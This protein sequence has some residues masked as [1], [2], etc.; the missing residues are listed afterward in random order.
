MLV[1]V[2]VRVRVRVGDIG[3]DDPFVM[4]HFLKIEWDCYLYLCEFT[5]YIGQ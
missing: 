3:E 2:R 5:L 1:R 4:I